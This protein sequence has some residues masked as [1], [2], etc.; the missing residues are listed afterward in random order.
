VK[1]NEL[2]A[3]RKRD[4]QAAKVRGEKLERYLQDGEP[5][6]DPAPELVPDDATRRRC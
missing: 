2:R 1:P 6:N 4:E 3:R 5:R